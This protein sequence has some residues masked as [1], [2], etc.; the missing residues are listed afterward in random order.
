MLSLKKIS[1]TAGLLLLLTSTAFAVLP[2]EGIYEKYA[3]DGHLEAR[4]Y[5]VESQTA[6]KYGL[7]QQLAELIWL[8]AYA[9]DGNVLGQMATK[10]IWKTDTAGAA[11]KALLL[12]KKQ[13]GEQNMTPSY[14]R[15]AAV[16]SFDGE[17]HVNVGMIDG[18][19]GESV[20]WASMKIAEVMK[21]SYTHVEG[22]V[23]ISPLLLAYM[24]EGDTYYKRFEDVNKVNDEVNQAKLR[25]YYTGDNSWELY[26]NNMELGRIIKQIASYKPNLRLE[27]CYGQGVITGTEV[28]LRHR[29]TVDS[30]I[31]GITEINE[32]VTVAGLAHGYDERDWC[33]VIRANGQKG[34]VAAQYCQIKK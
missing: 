22:S 32:K 11:E 24:L 19:E 4:M 15:D 29:P 13:F 16:F 30:G 33:Y 28:R 17:G 10:Y 31:L 20:T 12:D 18:F 26:E 6:V 1:L 27:K 21:G 7:G 25:L 34:F 8:E 3:G 5:V 14:A 2:V 23:E 9:A